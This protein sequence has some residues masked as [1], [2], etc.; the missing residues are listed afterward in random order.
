MHHGKN[1]LSQTLEWIYKYS[2]DIKTD[3]STISN[4]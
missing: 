4:R 3:L 1:L 2:Q